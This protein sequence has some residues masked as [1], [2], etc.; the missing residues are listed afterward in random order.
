MVFAAADAAECFRLHPPGQINRAL[1]SRPASPDFCGQ[2]SSN[3]NRSFTMT[4]NPT[5]RSTKNFTPQVPL[6]L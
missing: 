5:V 1:P 3:D 4:A 6:Y 2:F